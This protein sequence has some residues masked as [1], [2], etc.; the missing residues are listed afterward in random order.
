MNAEKTRHHS[1]SF[2]SLSL[3]LS[4]ALCV[5]VSVK[6]GTSEGRNLSCAV[7]SALLCSALLQ[8]KS[9]NLT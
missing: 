4:L 2:T 6:E 7:L 8:H 1:L 3:S 9:S 5:S